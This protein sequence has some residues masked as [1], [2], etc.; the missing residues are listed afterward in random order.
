MGE[1]C[2]QETTGANYSRLPLAG[3]PDI[4]NVLGNRPVPQ[5]LNVPKS[6]YQSPSGTSGSCD[7]QLA[8]SNRSSI[9]T[10]RSTVSQTDSLLERVL[11]SL[12]SLQNYNDPAEFA[13]DPLL[14][15]PAM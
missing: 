15:R 13:E 8:S 5:S 12:D 6:L 3:W 11:E 7:F 9:E 10:L 1:A 14:S 2:T 4:R